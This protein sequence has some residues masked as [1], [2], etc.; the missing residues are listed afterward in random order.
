MC[1]LKGE[2]DV[3]VDMKFKIY[4]FIVR[5]GEMMDINIIIFVLF[6]LIV[7]VV[8][9]FFVCKLIVEVKIVGVKF[10]VE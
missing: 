7:G 9:G 3:Y 5:G 8:V 2:Y 1:I 4:K 6:G 10:S